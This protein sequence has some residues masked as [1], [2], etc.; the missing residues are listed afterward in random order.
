MGKK[1]RGRLFF[2]CF[3]LVANGNVMR[4]VEK[5]A[6]QDSWLRDDIG[7]DVLE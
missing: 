2:F 5:C 4:N 7:I 6:N 1:V 3:Y